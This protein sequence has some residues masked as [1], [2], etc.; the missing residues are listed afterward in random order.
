MNFKRP[1]GTFL[2]PTPQTV[3]TTKPLAQQGFSAFT[4]PCD[5]TEDQF[6]ANADYLAGPNSRVSTRFFLANND[7][8]VT[9]SGNGLNPLGNI[10]GFP[11]PSNSEFVVFSLAHTHTF[12]NA[13]L[14]QA[15][16]GYVRTRTDTRAMTPFSWSDIGVAE[17]SMSDNN[18]LPSLEILGSVSIASGFPRTITQN[19]FVFNDDFSFVRGAHTIQFGGSLTR[20][21]DNVDLVGLGSL[22]RFLSWPDFLLGLN[23]GRNGTDFSNVF[24]SFDVFG[25]TTREYRVWGRIIVRPG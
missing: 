10:R 20:L 15:R 24:A 6:L 18:N 17:G 5:F 25:L 23:A 16:I 7:Q 3:D 12:H 1:D 2:I 13:S 22:V 9:F 21:Q 8:T 19:S 4:D 11:S 14:N